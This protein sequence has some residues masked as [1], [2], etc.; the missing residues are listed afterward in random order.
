MIFDEGGDDC[1]L[2]DDNPYPLFRI[3]RMG[4]LSVINLYKFV[5]GVTSDDVRVGDGLF[6][7]L[8]PIHFRVAS[9]NMCVITLLGQVDSGTAGIVKV[10]HTIALLW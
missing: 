2:A 4:G 6:N 1:A 5:G 3:I 9:A 7:I 10:E 8:D